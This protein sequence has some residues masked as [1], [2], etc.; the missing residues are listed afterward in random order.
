MEG[1]QER[2]EAAFCLTPMGAVLRRR[3]AVFLGAWFLVW[4]RSSDGVHPGSFAQSPMSVWCSETWAR[5]ALFHPR[6][7]SV[8]QH[9]AVAFPQHPICSHLPRQAARVKSQIEVNRGWVSYFQLCK[10]EFGAIIRC[11]RQHL[12]SLPGCIQCSC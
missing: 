9:E 8:S 10:S 3:T 1:A 6:L 4:L 2:P 12:R 5:A 7:Q 11:V